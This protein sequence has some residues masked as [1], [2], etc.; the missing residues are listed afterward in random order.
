MRDSLGAFTDAYIVAALWSSTDDHGTP[1]DQ[2]YDRENIHPDTLATMRAHCRAFF[3]ANETHILCD[4]GPTGPDGSSQ[5]EM[6]GHDFWLTRNGHGTGFWDGDWP[7]PHASALDEASK[8]FGSFDLYV[9]D[10]GMVHGG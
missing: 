1:L 5:V 7:E 3:F 8:A 9:G 2:D 10:D 6:A 4:G